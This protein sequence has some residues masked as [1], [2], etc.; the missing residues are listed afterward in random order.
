MNK[1]RMMKLLNLFSGVAITAV[2]A[3]MSVA[4]S[5]GDITI[6]I[7]SDPSTLDPQVR[8]D[9]NERAVN[10][11]IYETLMARTADG[12]LVP[13]L[14]AAAPVQKDATTWEFKLRPNIT[15]TN[16]EAFN[17][18]SVVAS[19][20]RIIDPALKSEQISYFG[21]IASAAKVDDLTVDVTT[22]GPDPILPS[23]M[24]WMKMVPA[25]YSSDPKF[26]QAPIGTGPYIFS[27]WSH[28]EDII[29]KANPN[30]WGGAPSIGQVTYRF[31]GEPG[32]RLSGLMAGELD[33]ITNL[34]PEFVSTVPKS[35]AVQG[36]ETSLIVL[37]TENPSTKDPRVRKALNLAIDRDAL[38]KNLFGGY[39]KSA[40]GQIVNPKAF[41]F[42]KDL[43]PYPYDPEQAKA[44]IKEAGAEGTTVTLQGEAGRWLKDRETIEAVA[45][46]WTAAGVK[47]DVQ[48]SEFGE[49][50]NRLFDK[51]HRPDAIFVANSDELLDADRPITSGYE[52]GASFASNN[53]QEMSAEAKA[54][55][56]ETDP[57]KRAAIYAKITQKAYD[58]NYLA[59]LLYSEDI[60][61]FSKR[62][63]WQPRVDSKLIVK[64]M[65]TTD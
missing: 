63:E 14:A 60:Y 11:N 31:I 48:I 49:Y 7:G 13:G 8:D 44:L 35:A 36:L 40:A 52:A 10:D 45:A 9:G 33:V 29:I 62:L 51:A 28:G 21:T 61:G 64:E 43:K 30:Y 15:F 47:V 22:K 54:A 25:K 12:T 56:I 16:G 26:A 50:L 46:Y 39:A 59:P 2:T 53:D 32:T 4:A 5:A 19:I 41:G 57:A 65:K 34:L 55:R 27:E 20:S 38:A 6:A 3:L 58:D 1:E 24:Y 17:A 18:D 42:N 37:S 23:R